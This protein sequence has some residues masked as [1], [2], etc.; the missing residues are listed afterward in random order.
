[1]SEGPARRERLVEKIT[2]SFT[3][4]HGLNPRERAIVMGATRIGIIEA[5]RGTMYMQ[6]VSPSRRLEMEA[7]WGMEGIT[8]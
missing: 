5:I 3:T 6:N 8:R 7:Y 1:V 2:D 4:E